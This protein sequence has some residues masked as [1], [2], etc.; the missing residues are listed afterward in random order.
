M[1]GTLKSDSMMSIILLAPLSRPKSRRFCRPG[2]IQSGASGLAGPARA[3]CG[4]ICTAAL[5]ARGSLENGF[6]N[7]GSTGSAA[8]YSTSVLIGSFPRRVAA[9]S[10]ATLSSTAAKCILGAP[11][12]VPSA[13]TWPGRFRQVR[14]SNF[15]HSVCCDDT[16]VAACW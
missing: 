1:G 3:G 16:P 14:L 6:D 7:R 11:S 5:L 10:T 2:F 13:C 9:L 4:S 12:K 15:M 8:P